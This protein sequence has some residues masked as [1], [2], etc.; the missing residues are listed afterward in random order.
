MR[1]FLISLLTL[2]CLHSGSLHAEDVIP[3]LATAI[4]QDAACKKI[5][6]DLVSLSKQNRQLEQGLEKNEKKLTELD[7]IRRLK[8]AE[9]KA[10]HQQM[11]DLITAI[12]RLSRHGPDS[13]LQATTTPDELIRGVILMRSL[14]KWA[15]ETNLGLQSE[16][17]N[18]T[19]LRQTID[20]EKSNLEANRLALQQQ[21]KKMTRLLT[22]RRALL[23]KELNRRKKIAERV[24]KLAEKAKN[25]RELVG[26]ISSKKQKIAAP[27]ATLSPDLTGKYTILPVQGPVI[28][29]FGKPSSDN[30]DGL[31]VVFQARPSAWVLAPITGQII[32]A[33][34]FRNYKNMVII[35]HEQKGYYTILAGLNTLSA[36]VGQTVDAGEP[37]GTMNDQ[38]TS[39][40]YLE[41]RRNEQTINPTKW[42]ENRQ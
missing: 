3:S 31:G 8:T 5:N 21:S 26:K 17:G 25:I 18:L 38:K 6:R 30:L 16:L 32:F 23:K 42:I 34:P 10:R 20:Q 29:A 27:S 14:M 4:K 24:K 28:E 15:H 22:R 33:G 7:Q 41:L 2:G 13:L 39:K 19:L 40:L 11:Q 9:L 35:K 37:L 36:D 1:L 12:G